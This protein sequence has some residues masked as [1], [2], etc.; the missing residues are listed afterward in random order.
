MYFD[1]S[2]FNSTPKRTMDDNIR[3]DHVEIVED[4]VDWAD[5]PTNRDR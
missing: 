5:L 2:A 3:I 4:G 1:L